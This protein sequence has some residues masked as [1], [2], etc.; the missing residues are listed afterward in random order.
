MNLIIDQGNTATK[1]ALFEGD[2]LSEKK[3]FSKSNQ[4]EIENWIESQVSSNANVLV[5]SVT[6]DVL[7]IN[8][9]TV[10]ILDENTP[11]PIGNDYHTPQTLGKDRIA[12]AVAIW[13]KN[14]Q[15]NTLCIDIGTCIKYDLVSASG[16]YLG[17][18]IS[19]GIEMR[20]KALNT[21]TDRLPL[22]EPEAFEFSYGKDT[23]TSIKNGVQQAV[24]H[25]I[26]GFIQRYEQ[27]F[28]QLTIF[29]TG[30]GAKFFDKGFKN[31]IFAIPVT[32]WA[33]LTVFGLN[34]ILKHNVEGKK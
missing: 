24:F 12:N 20:Y 16:K 34:E 9:E 8:K 19:P 5:S 23:E 29:M 7:K 11:L 26:N 18:N 33:D 28:G 31:T 17:G 2:I 6:N 25:E 27:E 15:K 3:M 14:P 21:F 1:L 30:G 10:I 32:F 4:A 22:I 13:S